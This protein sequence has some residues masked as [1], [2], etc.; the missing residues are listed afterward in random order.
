M[1]IIKILGIII[2]II[3]LFIVSF[4]LIPFK[5][6][7]IINN[8]YLNICIIELKF[9]FGLI[10]VSYNK[11]LKINMCGIKINNIKLNNK[12]NKDKNKVYKLIMNIIKTYKRTNNKKEIKN[13][14]KKALNIIL[15]IFK[16]KN[17][18]TEIILST[19]NPAHTGIITGL[20]S[21]FNIFYE[22]LYVYTDFTLRNKFTYDIFIEGKFT[23]LYL[24]KQ[25]LKL[26]SCVDLINYIK[27]IKTSTKDINTSKV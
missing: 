23:I 8:N 9:M 13:D 16:T 17:F 15:N 7:V 1:I 20:I 21:Y 27:K 4:L 10:S 14:F 24:L 5:Y 2:S 26:K 25:C 19:K 6:R 22:N 3:I 12:K 11:K 18:K